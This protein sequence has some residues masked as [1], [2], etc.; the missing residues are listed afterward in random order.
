MGDPNQWRAITAFGERDPCTVGGSGELDVLRIGTHR[1]WC[2]RGRFGFSHFNI[3]LKTPAVNCLDNRLRPTGVANR[4]SS[5]VDPCADR[6][7]RHA[8]PVPNDFNEVVFGR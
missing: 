7:V 1:V 5:G 6:R 8:Q 2:L 3:Q 4:L